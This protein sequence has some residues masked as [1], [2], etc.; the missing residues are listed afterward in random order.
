MSETSSAGEVLHGSATHGGS[1][2]SQPAD[3]ADADT[4]RLSSDADPRSNDG[5]SSELTAVST[6]SDTNR[7]G[8]ESCKIETYSSVT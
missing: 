4:C 8:Y 2:A 6:M 3:D 7:C 1:I 5:V